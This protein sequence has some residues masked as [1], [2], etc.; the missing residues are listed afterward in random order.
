MLTISPWT[1][2]WERNYFA[3][4]LPWLGTWMLNPYVR[5]AVTGVGIVTAIVGMRDLS[6]VILARSGASEQAPPAH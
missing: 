3:H 5:G 6:T 4:V 1:I 2:F